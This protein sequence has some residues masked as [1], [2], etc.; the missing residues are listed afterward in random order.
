MSDLGWAEHLE[1]VR[2]AIEKITA[3]RDE[4]VALLRRFLRFTSGSSSDV[5][6][7]AEEFLRRIDAKEKP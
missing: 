5:D 6:Y 4:A 2:Q 1:C 3:E 7:D